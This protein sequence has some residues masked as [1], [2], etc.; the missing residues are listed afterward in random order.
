MHTDKYIHNEKLAPNTNLKTGSY[1]LVSL[2][3]SSKADLLFKTE[4]NGFNTNQFI[5]QKLFIYNIL[6]NIKNCK[7]YAN[8]SFKINLNDFVQ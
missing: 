7:N 8:I 5:L 1:S 3:R 2:Y 4:N 6:N